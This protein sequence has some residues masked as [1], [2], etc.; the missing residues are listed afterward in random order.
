[1][2][3]ERYGIVG[4]GNWI[5]DKIKTISH[6]PGEGNLCSIVD[7]TSSPGGGPCNVLFDIAAIDP[8]FPLYAAGR[9]GHDADGEVLINEIKKRNINMDAMIVTDGVS[10][11]Y[12]DVMS[13]EGKR[14]F[15]QCRGAN[16]KFT[17]ADLQK[18]D[19]PAKFFYLGYLLLLDAF[20]EIDPATGKPAAVEALKMMHQKGYKTIVDFVS[21]APE[22]FQSIVVPALPEIDILL[23]NEIE[24][25]ACCNCVLRDG[26]KLNADLLPAAV[27]RLFELGVRDIVVI[28]F[29]EGAAGRTR[30][31]KYFFAPSCHIETEDIVG[32]CGAGDAFAAATIYALHQNWSLEEAVK[33]GSASSYFNLHNATAT[34]GAVSL[35]EMQKFLENC[36]FN[37][38]L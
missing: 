29:P 9:V 24:A 13:G 15:F 35:A 14:T 38:V 3:Q 21:D 28:H 6:W 4:A 34:E 2:Q 31:G 27:D 20:D 16:A 17:P 5:L 10:T 11:S 32:S 7:E 30:D 25:Q 19:A 26:D 12:T 33:L 23:V 1:M 36:Q 18:I 22:R 37:P 8:A